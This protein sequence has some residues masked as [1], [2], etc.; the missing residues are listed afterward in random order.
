MYSRIDLNFL[1]A[2]SCAAC[3]VFITMLGFAQL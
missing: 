1:G 3:N 2:T